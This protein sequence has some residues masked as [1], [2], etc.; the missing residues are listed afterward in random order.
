MKPHPVEALGLRLHEI[1]G[2]SHQ[3]PQLGTAC[4]SEH[5]ASRRRSAGI[6]ENLEADLAEAIAQGRLAMQDEELAADI[7][8]GIWLQVTRG[9]LE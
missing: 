2:E 5:A 1:P 7:V 3:R 9:S 8:I 4:G 6:R